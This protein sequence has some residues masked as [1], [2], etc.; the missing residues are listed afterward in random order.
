MGLSNSKDTWQQRQLLSFI[1]R[2]QDGE[3]EQ[4]L[5]AHPEL[6]NSKL[7]NESTNTMCRASFLGY[8]NIVVLLVK[9]GADVNHCSQNGRSPLMWACYRNHTHVIDFLLES[10]ADVSIRDST[11]L[12]AFEM[13]VTIVNYESALML[14][15]R[16][17]QDTP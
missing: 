8:K 14:R 10:G 12:N 5:R 9:H 15:Q 17:A 16:A 4:F 3:L 2:N 11:G 13:A 7:C 6:A 1:E